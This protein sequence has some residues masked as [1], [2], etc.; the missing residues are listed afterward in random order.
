MR[1]ET[2]DKPVNV[3]FFPGLRAA[4][5]LAEYWLGQVTVRL[6]REICWRMKEPKAASDNLSESLGMQRYWNEKKA[7]FNNDATAQYLTQRLQTPPPEPGT[8]ARGSFAWLLKELALDNTSAFLLALGL[9]P[10][11]DSA[12]GSVMAACQNDP[13][14]TTATF[15]LAQ[16]LWDP[17]EQVLAIADPA[18]PL[19]RFGLL[20]S[21]PQSVLTGFIAWN[22]PITVPTP[23]ARQLLF[24]GS[25]L[26]WSLS[27]VTQQEEKMR[28]PDLDLRQVSASLTAQKEKKLRIVP[29]VG[30]QG[31]AHW[32]TVQAAARAVEGG[33]QQLA[34]C[35]N[36]PW[37]DEMGS[38]LKSLLSCCW[39]KGTVLYMRQAEGAL[40]T[41]EH[42]RQRM[43]NL[44]PSLRTIPVTLFIS[45][46]H[47][48]QLKHIPPDL[49]LPAL[50]VPGMSFQQR[51]ELWR[52]LLGPKSTG[53]E[54]AIAECSRRFRYEQ[55]ELHQVV[56]EIK[57]LPG[58]VTRDDLTTACRAHLEMDLGELAQKVTPRFEGERLILPHKQHTQFEE[59]VNAMES[60]T[61]VH[62]EWG[63][64]EAWNES[65]ISVL[66]AG[67]PGTGKTMGAEILA[68]SLD[69]PM[70]RIDLSQVVNK[71]IGETE[72]NLK[73]LFD[74]A[75]TSDMILFFDEADSLF[76]RR[77]E[78]KDAHDRYANLEIS[79]LLERMERFKGL[80]ILATNRRQDLDEAFLRRLRYI[81]DFPFPGVEQRKTIW[82]QIIPKTVDSSD[83]EVGYLA[84]RFQLTGGHIRS[85]VL[86]ACLQSAGI[87]DEGAAKSLKKGN[88]HEFK[89]VLSMEN[90]IVAVKREF[91]KMDRSVSLEHFGPYAGVVKAMEEEKEKQ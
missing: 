3:S 41:A 9:A 38:Y 54:D 28:Q 26:P 5:S 45:V 39:L 32:E 89:G 69:L 42:C 74:A 24:P 33:G 70:Y 10:V 48:S 79:Y 88:K 1:T 36:L 43:E 25:P 65:G 59:V 85:V 17:P 11:F 30:R 63:T 16:K 75:D 58:P 84:R 14:K 90:V 71:Y 51:R 18:H 83:V 22:N 13:A 82:S 56:A 27:L 40:L 55:E 12:V 80:A 81:I 50:P 78:V 34:Q 60:L 62:Y 8:P 52:N 77:T 72:K 6:R 67:P 53:L 19:F 49:L 66:F 57:T 73:K 87:H 44:W 2:L 86:N 23:V 35:V 21:P 61:K 47:R 15:S 7:F 64:A 29:V 4:D 20:H 91:D 68:R 46:N 76:G 37:P 31:A